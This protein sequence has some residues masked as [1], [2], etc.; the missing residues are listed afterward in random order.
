MATFKVKGLVSGRV[1]GVGFRYFVM[2]R[3]RALGL[4]GHAI[5]LESGQV[6]VLLEGDASSVRQM[7][8]LVERGPITSRVDGVDWLDASDEPLKQA[9]LT[10]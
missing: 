8:E 7:Q 2:Q 3:A 4:V 6:E 10:G 5:N 9:F 1:Q